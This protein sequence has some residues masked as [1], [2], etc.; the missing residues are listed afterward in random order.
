MSADSINQASISAIPQSYIQAAKKAAYLSAEEER[1]LAFRWRNQKDKRAADR[2]I[3]AHLR[4]VI[5]MAGKY[6]G[7]GLPIEDLVSEGN[8]GM[9]KALDNFEPKLG[10][11]FSTYATWWIRAALND[12]VIFN[13][14]LVKMGTTADQKRLFFNLRNVKAQLGAYGDGELSFDMAQMIASNLRTTPQAVIEMNARIYGDDTLN[15][16]PKPDLPEIIE[17]IEDDAERQDFVIERKQTRQ[18]HR[19]ILQIGLKDMKDRERD[20]FVR[21]KMIRNPLTLEQL[22]AVYGVSRERIRQIEAAA[23]KKF[24]RTTASLDRQYAE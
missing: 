22:G 8:I 2:I 5:R 15:V 13:S 17:G 1:D 20:I 14:S 19:R 6:F 21:R 4:L 11:R 9:L 24:R 10:F 12:F 16:R 23:T 18:L 7:Y 3:R